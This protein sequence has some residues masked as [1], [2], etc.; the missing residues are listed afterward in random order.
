MSQLKQPQKGV[1]VYCMMIIAHLTWSFLAWGLLE[2]QKLDKIL[3][4]KRIPLLIKPVDLNS[5]E[6][7]CNG[8][9]WGC[10]ATCS[11]T[12]WCDIEIIISYCVKLITLA[13]CLCVQLV[14][15]GWECVCGSATQTPLFTCLDCKFS[16]SVQCLGIFS[17]L[18]NCS[19]HG[20][21]LGIRQR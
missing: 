6:Q 17:V 15:S 7:C 4:R 14:F 20:I 21:S 10:Q 2:K 5:R 12:Y 11:T 8:H 3:A 13:A 1:M 19:D 18:L 16:S 9:V